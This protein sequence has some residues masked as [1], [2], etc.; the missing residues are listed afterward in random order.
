MIEIAKQIYSTYLGKI[1]KLLIWTSAE[2]TGSPPWPD[3]PGYSIS[4]FFKPKKLDKIEN[5]IKQLF[6]LNT[7]RG[8]DH[9]NGSIFPITK[10]HF[11]WF[12]KRIFF[13]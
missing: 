10:Y 3:Q 7:L 12:L 13:L 4:V 6:C 9:D 1:Y 11:S 8:Q 5:K 2:R